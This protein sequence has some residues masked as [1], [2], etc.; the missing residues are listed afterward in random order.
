MENRRK[1][2]LKTGKTVK[3]VLL[4]NRIFLNGLSDFPNEKTGRGGMTLNR[5]TGRGNRVRQAIEAVEKSEK[6]GA[7]LSGARAGSAF[8]AFLFQKETGR[9]GRPFLKIRR[10][11]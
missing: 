7:D 3:I 10:R 1:P 6:L 5:K 9:G 2:F 4:K 8:F 11:L